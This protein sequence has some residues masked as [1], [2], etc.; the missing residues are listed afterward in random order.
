MHIAMTVQ[1][2]ACTLISISFEINVSCFSERVLTTEFTLV[3][4]ACFLC[5]LV[6]TSP[7]QDA[8]V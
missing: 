5:H 3:T 4:E 1:G 8:E 6:Y 2:L 7:F